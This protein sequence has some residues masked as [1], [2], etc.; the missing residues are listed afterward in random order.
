MRGAGKVPKRRLLCHGAMLAA[1]LLGLFGCDGAERQSTPPPELA[2]GAPPQSFSA[3]APLEAPTDLAPARVRLGKALFRDTRLSADGIVACSS[4]HD[5]RNGGDDG[6]RVSIGIGGIEGLVNAPS[7]LNAGL[8]FAQFWDG[9][10]YTLEQQ[11]S[12]TLVNP[13]EMGAD[14]TRVASELRGDRHLAQEFAVAY[15]G[16][17]TA[18]NLVDALATYVRA[19]VTPS[20]PFDRYLLG[21][22]AALDAEAR[23]GYELFTRLGCVSC[24]QGRNI[25]GNFFQRFGVMGD[26][27]ADRGSVS[28]VDYGRYNVTSRE[29]DRYKFKV[30]SLRNVAKT[31]P[32][33]H[34]GSAASLEEAVQIMVKYQLGRDAEPNQVA[35]LVAFL[36][37]LSG[38]VPQPLL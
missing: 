10:A 23:S 37:S 17:L 3:F 11:I 26:Y 24:H 12:A 27:F 6:R 32:Y 8:N 2:A 31:A 38:T 13:I 20:S 5:V 1:S 7:V 14:L 35:Q 16:G 9:R 36:E 18:D 34:D 22:I 15:D 28:T 29:Q 19:L 33:F 25:G 30:P 4:C 21:D